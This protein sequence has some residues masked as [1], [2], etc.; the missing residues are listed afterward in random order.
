MSDESADLS[1]T[2]SLRPSRD[3]LHP[4]KQTI[5]GLKGFVVFTG[6]CLAAY[7]LA[8]GGGRP[9]ADGKHQVIL[10]LEGII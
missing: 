1:S 3:L 10:F 4:F 9:P 8:E 2:S 7:A 5:G 6:G